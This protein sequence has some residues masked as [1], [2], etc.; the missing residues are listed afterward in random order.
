MDSFESFYNRLGLLEYPFSSKTTEND[1]GREKELFVDLI[2]YSPIKESFNQGHSIILIG[3]RGTGKTAILLDFYRGIQKKETLVCQ[4]SDYSD[5]SD[6]YSK[7][8]FYKFLVIQLSIELFN[9]IYS[10]GF[11]KKMRS[12]NK[13][14]KIFLSYLLKEYV[15]SL[16]KQNL[17]DK[18]EQ[19]QV[20]RARLVL[21]TLFGWM[22]PVLN[23][24]ATVGS[25][26]IDDYLAKHFKE[27]PPINKTIDIKNIFPEFPSSVEE[28]FTSQKVGFRF[29][30]EVIRIIKK[31]GYKDVKILLD[32]IDED[33]RIEDDG[34]EI[35][36]FILPIVTNKQLLLDSSVQIVFAIWQTPFNFIRDKVRTQ[37]LNCP[38]IKWTD[39][40]LENVLNKRLSIFSKGKINH[41]YELFEK[42]ISFHELKLIFELSNGNPRDLW[43]LMDK[44]IRKQFSE[45]KMLN[46]IQRRYIQLGIEDFI[47][48][49]NYYE[50]YPRKKNARANS[51]DIYSYAAHL[52]KLETEIFTKNNLSEM[53]G[54]GRSTSNYVQSM[55][56]IGLIEKHSKKINLVSYRIKDPKIIYAMKNN[57]LIQK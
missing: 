38:I 54:T 11:R 23:Y 9:N 19:I 33:E 32:K 3:D 41:Y 17:K 16:S 20:S 6:K 52:L 2:Q 14:E 55:E 7:K 24:G 56:K 48:T 12:L 45:V 13:E 27:L 35:S 22:R 31:I 8:E 42:D 57:L 29:L 40:D 49:F 5:L 18:I 26:M 53:A 44:I 25:I 43:H 50:Y 39:E 51:M 46:K 37:K 28:N 4:V 34:E 1:Q 30:E 47:T 36:K 15:P 10:K 21:N